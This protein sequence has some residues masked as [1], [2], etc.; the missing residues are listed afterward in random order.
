MGLLF[1]TNAEHSVS[2]GSPGDPAAQNQR[3][4]DDKRH[5]KKI[6][7]NASVAVSF[8]EGH[9]EAESKYG[10]RMQIHKHLKR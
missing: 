2:F 4:L 5:E 8:Q 10:D 9:Y 1:E 7:T 3:P 6:K